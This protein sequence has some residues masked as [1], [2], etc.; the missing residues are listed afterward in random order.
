MPFLAILPAVA[1]LL[2]LT[3]APAPAPVSALT[4]TLFHNDGSMTSE[5]LECQPT[6]GTHPHSDEACE[7]LSAVDGH[8]AQLPAQADTMC[9]AIYAQV[10]A[11]ATG[12]WRKR[13]VEFRHV[14]S[15]A[16]VAGV[17]TAGVFNFS[18]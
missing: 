13:P 11:T 2:S 3:V 16:C 12:H 14:Y 8:F 17:E 10:L 18:R 9:L 15:N 5:T 6:G 1:S 7:A 4:L